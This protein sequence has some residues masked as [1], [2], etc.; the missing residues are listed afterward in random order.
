[1]VYFINCHSVTS[2]ALDRHLI[3][4]QTNI[5]FHVLY[6]KFS[7]AKLNDIYHIGNASPSCHLTV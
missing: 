5:F 6:T 3:V 7:F 1:M 4:F 2:F